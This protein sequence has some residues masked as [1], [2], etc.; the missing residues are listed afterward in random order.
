M[1]SSE[2]ADSV[3]MCDAGGRG[4]VNYETFWGRSVFAYT[5]THIIQACSVCAH[6]CGHIMHLAEEEVQSF[7]HADEF[8]FIFGPSYI[9]KSDLSFVHLFTFCSSRELHEGDVMLL[10]E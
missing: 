10:R 7:T 3:Q 1:N 5:H 2:V 6:T 4:H 9:K 8:L